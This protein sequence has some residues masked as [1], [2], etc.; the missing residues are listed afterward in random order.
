MFEVEISVI[1]PIYNIENYLEKCI[2]SLL[3]QKFDHKYEIILV[4]DGSTDGSGTIADKYGV[5]FNIIKVFH[6]ENGDYP[7]QEIMV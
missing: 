4:D 7:V 6:K 3:S 1:V 2:N 5:E